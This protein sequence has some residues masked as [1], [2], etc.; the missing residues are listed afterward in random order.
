[1][2]QESSN[3]QE[4]QRLDKWLWAAR[5]FK[6]RS[7]A[8]SAINGGMVHLE[9][10]RIKASRKIRP[11]MRLEITQGVIRWEIIIM[12][13]NAQRRPAVEAQQLYEETPESLELRTNLAER[14][15]QEEQRRQRRI[16]R[17]DKHQRRLLSRIKQ[18]PEED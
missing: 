15:R 2:A 12:N 8:T 11:G 10:Q 9:G 7:A 17:P 18:Q 6:N 13:L 16:G 4:S 14:Q 5:F 3:D 1:M